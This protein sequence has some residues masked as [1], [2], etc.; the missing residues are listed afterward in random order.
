MFEIEIDGDEQ[1]KGQGVASVDFWITGLDLLMRDSWMD[2]G[3]GWVADR[4]TLKN[5]QDGNLKF[6]I[7]GTGM[8]VWNTTS[9][10][11]DLNMV[12]KKADPFKFYIANQWILE[13]V[14]N[15]FG[16]V[17]QIIMDAMWPAILK[18]L[19]TQLIA[20]FN[21][22]TP[23][24]LWPEVKVAV[25]GH[26]N[27]SPIAGGYTGQPMKLTADIRTTFQTDAPKLL[28]VLGE[29][30][31]AE[32]VAEQQME[33]LIDSMD[34]ET[35]WAENKENV[36]ALL[37]RYNLK[38]EFLDQPFN[39]TALQEVLVEYAKEKAGAFM[40]ALQPFIDAE[41][42]GAVFQGLGAEIHLGGG[43][44]KE[45]GLIYIQSLAK[46]ARD[47][48]GGQKMFTVSV[49][50]LQQ[51]GVDLV[52]P[53]AGGVADIGLQGL[54]YDKADLR[55]SRFYAKDVRVKTGGKN[56][57]AVKIFKASAAT[58]D[59]EVKMPSSWD[60][61]SSLGA[62]G[63]AERRGAARGGR[64]GRGTTTGAAAG[65][66]IGG[67]AR[68][69]RVGGFLGG[70]WAWPCRRGAARRWCSSRSWK[71]ARPGPGR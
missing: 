22:M 32:A 53:P 42:G 41:N 9:L 28:K 19:P 64:P 6:R 40:D 27:P 30:F 26:T 57:T 36:R 20:S 31:D 46:D 24:E 43:W 3:A 34:L 5:G 65:D 52:A 38:P 14:L 54:V 55:L 11:W 4:N 2:W 18:A 39:R 17:D 49:S 67:N 58:K 29:D 12:E 69:A 50:L 68:V 63:A 13:K 66:S 48:Q 51:F 15:K 8:A 16:G 56:G 23:S 71:G 59:I 70:G 61:G 10:R 62:H 1:Y 44:K 33:A 35:L 25:R 60:V 47:A 45:D 7:Q 21:D 37:S